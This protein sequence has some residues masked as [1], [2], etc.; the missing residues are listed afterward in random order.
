MSDNTTTAGPQIK[1][2]IS[3]KDFGGKGYLLKECVTYGTPD[4]NGNYPGRKVQLGTILG[5]ATGASRKIGQLP[6]GTARESIVIEGTFEAHIMKD[7]GTINATAV[8]LPEAFAAHIEQAFKADNPPESIEFAV[9]IGAEPTPNR[10]VGYQYTVHSLVKPTVVD[11]LA[12]LKAKMEEARRP[13]LAAPVKPAE[14]A[15]KPAE[16][17]E[18]KGKAGKTA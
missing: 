17:A 1:R 14:P 8:F 13:Q 9:E 18:P 3:M 5:R 6:D 7:G 10:G 4:S 2:A 15:T 11:P 12:A 16:P